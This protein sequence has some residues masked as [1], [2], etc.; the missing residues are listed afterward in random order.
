LFPEVAIVSREQNIKALTLGNE[1]IAVEARALTMKPQDGK[2]VGTANGNTVVVKGNVSK[3]TVI[4]C[5]VRVPVSDDA[6]EWSS[7]QKLILAL[8]KL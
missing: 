4:Q 5:G 7:W 2:I 8:L 1:K 3:G 6:P